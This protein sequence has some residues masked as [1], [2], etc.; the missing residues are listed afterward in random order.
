[1]STKLVEFEACPQNWWNSLQFVHVIGGIYSESTNLVHF[2][3]RLLFIDAFGFNKV[4]NAFYNDKEKKSKHR[5]FNQNFSNFYH[6]LKKIITH[7]WRSTEVNGQAKTFSGFWSQQTQLTQMMS[8][9]YLD[10]ILMPASTLKQAS[11]FEILA[12]KHEIPL[13]MK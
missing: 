9:P 5:R 12:G 3:Q 10:L 1:M 7:A 2:Y 11:K 13:F 4:L 8:K 6:I